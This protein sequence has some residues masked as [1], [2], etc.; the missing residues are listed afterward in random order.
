MKLYDVDGYDRPLMLSDEH[1][2][3]GLL[4]AACTVRRVHDRSR[5]V[6]DATDRVRAELDRRRSSRSR[7]V[8]GT[9]VRHRRRRAAL[10]VRRALS[11]RHQPEKE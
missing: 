8:A 1:D 2:S 10:G 7:R 9:Y 6:H 11:R 5:H 4:C 3:R